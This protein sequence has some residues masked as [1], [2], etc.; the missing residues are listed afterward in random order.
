MKL[1][2]LALFVAVA[3]GVISTQSSAVYNLYKK[4]GLSLDVNGEVNV[5]F[6]NDREQFTYQYDQPGWT[7]ITS[8]PRQLVTGTYEE[9]TDRRTRLGQDDGASWMDIRGSQKLPQ[10]WRVTGTI[11]FGYA[12]SGSGMYLNSANL[13]FDKLNVGSISL[14][15]QYLHTGYVTR[16]GTFTT[17]DTFSGAS[18]RTDYTAIPNLHLSAYYSTPSSSDVRRNSNDEVEGWGASAS[19]RYPIADN[20]SVRFAA[21]YSDSRANPQLVNN[22]NVPQRNGN[23]VP[24]DS[25][26]YAGS[27]EY[28]HGN[29][30]AAVDA[31]RGEDDLSGNV[32]DSAKTDFV[33]V[34]LGYQFTPR[35][36]MTAGYGQQETKR[37]NQQGVTVVSGSVG[38]TGIRQNVA[39][40]YEPFLFPKT[41][42]TRAYIRGDYYLR[43]NVRL[44]GRID[45]VELQHELDGKDFANLENTAYRAGVSF[46]F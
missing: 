23:Q 36:S 33:G 11:G 15:R 4:D 22:N 2:A 35:F 21:G 5:H 28:R 27:V 37:K 38:A 31:G 20:H 29:F 42:E 1:K 13:A 32:I 8:D 10:D 17:L 9:R 14:G 44:Y 30:L 3:S 16:T 45:S 43:D 6:K 12:D 34:K 40:A 39:A 46:T 26:G 25:K 19:Y 41:E 18:I 24:V 7:S